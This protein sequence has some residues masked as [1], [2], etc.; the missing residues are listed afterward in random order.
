[1]FTR[2]DFLTTAG[3]LTGA[4]LFGGAALTGRRS[5]AADGDPRRIVI[6][7]EGNGI[8][9]DCVRD[10]LTLETLA[11]HA[12]KPIESSRDY[13]H[14]DPVVVPAA[15]LAEARSL[16][17][18]AGVDDDI[19]LV[20]RACLVLG[21]SATYLGGG[22]STDFGALSASRAA[23]GPAGPT[24]ESVLSAIPEVRGNTPFDAIRIGV[25]AATTPLNYVSCAFDA[26]KPA[27][28]LLSPA[29]AFASLFGSVASGQAGEEFE[30][31]KQLLE[32]ALEDVT[33]EL[34]TF[35]G[36]KRGRAKL[37]TYEASL[38]TM[39]ARN[40]QILG[41]KGAL[42]AVKP[43]GPGEADPD[44]YQS[45]DPLEQL[46]LQA[47]IATASLLAGL[48]NVAVI[49]F[50]AGSYYWSLQY[51]SLVD[52]YPGQQMLGGHDLRHG[53]SPA[54]YEVLHEVTSRG[55]AEMARM[56]RTLA[57][58]PEQGGT[59]LDNTLLLYM[60]DNGEKHHSN[61]E[62]WAMLLLGG[63]NM[64]FKTDGRSVTYPKSGHEN[65][66]QTSNLFNSLLHGAGLPTD[67]F[68]HS[69]PATRVAEGPLAE[70]WG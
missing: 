33:R 56:A 50:G 6:F 30:T 17:A 32:F 70:V 14:D 11:G 21:L 67:D 22:H 9:P 55:V 43:L 64:G 24:I 41:M 60:S 46:R 66:R 19:S 27:P 47:D 15:P 28:L 16:G 4:G 26:G 42:Q 1:M 59:M 69:D 20:E 48:T 68:G 65:N 18:L 29:A 23:G 39:L 36:S 57:A 63:N 38:L 51:P 2:R 37:E 54:F 44:P 31:R 58:H 62:E 35:S 12:G 3:L 40:D 8:R 52:L 25:G 10:P 34:K 13:G 45:D 5:R 49:S 53:E 61:S 7:L